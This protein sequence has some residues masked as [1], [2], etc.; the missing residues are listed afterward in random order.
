MKKTIVIAFL[1]L[2]SIALSCYAIAE[3]DPTPAVS[4]TIVAAETEAVVATDTITPH[5]YNGGSGSLSCEIPAGIELPG[6][7]SMGCSVS[8]RE[9][10]YA[11]CGIG[12]VC[13]PEKKQ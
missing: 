12:C 3:N 7:V 1:T 13:L 5:C 11:C 4:D 2:A 10:Y 9:G 6:G 8:C